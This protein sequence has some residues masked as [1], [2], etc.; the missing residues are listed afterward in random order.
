[1]FELGKIAVAVAS[2][3]VIGIGLLVYFVIPSFGFP[4]DLS[5]IIKLDDRL[6]LADESTQRMLIVT[7]SVGVEGID[8]SVVQAQLAD[9]YSIENHSSNGL[10]LIS[11]RIYIGRMIE[12]DPEYII[13]VLRPELMGR[14]SPINTE[15]ASAMRR[16][17]FHTDNPWINGPE[18]AG[19]GPEL[20]DQF[21]VSDTANLISMRTIPLRHLNEQVRMKTRRGIL[22]AKP[23]ELSAPYQMDLMLSEDK[24]DRHILDVSSMLADRTSEGN[25][26]GLAFIEQ[27][28]EQITAAG[29]TPILVIAPTHPG[30]AEAIGPAEDELVAAIAEISAR[31]NIAVI[32]LKRTLSADLFSDAIHPSRDG[33]NLLSTL[34]GEQLN[35]TVEA[36][37]A[38]SDKAEP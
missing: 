17:G 25:R 12:S 34:L 6:A 14:I 27:T 37:K 32:D 18:I 29:V 28:V 3:I 20:R 21:A 23:M 33:A 16:A 13:W 9:G 10:D 35:Q 31:N 5:R 38:D 4:G 11:A 22:P 30:G 19:I 2:G 24:L 7:N 1:M 26:D 8:G 36:Q 15:V